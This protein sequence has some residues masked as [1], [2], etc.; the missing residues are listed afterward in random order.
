MNRRSF[1]ATT[2]GTVTVATAG[3]TSLLEASIP[4]ELEDVD[5]DQQLPTPTRGDGAVTVEV[6]E[7]MGC[8]HCQDFQA[9]V[10]PVL[11]DEYIDQDEIEY[12]HHDFV[13]MASDASLAMA[14]AARAIQ[15]ETGTDDDPNGE[16]FA[17]KAA[18]MAADPDSGD[19]I[20]ALADEVDVD[21]E[22]VTNALENE[23]YYPT[24]AAD[25]E[26][27]DEEGVEGTP[28]VIVDGEVVDEPT[29]P[30]AVVDAI[31]EAQ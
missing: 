18:V 13:V 31:A 6:Y 9:D 3:C 10:F 15:D 11:E 29:D 16:F 23:T 21:P 24:L 20:A 27:G 1:L 28:T 2:V 25:W 22:V 4:D 14:N 17:Y 19:E 8:P 12:R 26:H 30:D 5:P 7:D